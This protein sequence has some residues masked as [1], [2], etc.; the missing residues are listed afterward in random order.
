[1]TTAIQAHL[2]ILLNLPHTTFIP[3][4]VCVAAICLVLFFLTPTFDNQSNGNGARS[5]RPGAA[6]PTTTP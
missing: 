1:M 6:T 3:F 5:A 2:A 4:I